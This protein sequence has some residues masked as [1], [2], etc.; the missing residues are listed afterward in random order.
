VRIRC[1]KRSTSDC[2]EMVEQ[3]LK[4]T[5]VVLPIDGPVPAK[6]YKQ[7]TPSTLRF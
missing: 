2:A 7:L 5:K 1:E 3:I 4:R 6:A